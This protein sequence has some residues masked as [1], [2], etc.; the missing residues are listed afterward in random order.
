M[1]SWSV[2]AKIQ[3]IWCEEDE[4]KMVREFLAEFMSTYVMME[5]LTRMLQLCLFTITDQENNPALPGTHALVISILVVIIRVSHGINTGYAINPSRD[6]PPSIFT[7]I[8]GWGKQVFSDGENWWWVPVVAPLLGASLGGIIYL[9]F[10]GSTIP[11]EPLKLEDSV[12]YED[13]G[14]TVLP[15]MGSHE[16]MISPLTLISVSLANRSSVH[17]APPLHESMALEHF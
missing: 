11:R 8:A 13:H 4:R 7:F 14:I 3:E 16:P 12:A 17:S 1:V 9:V 5:W 15:K 6:P 2:I 10:I